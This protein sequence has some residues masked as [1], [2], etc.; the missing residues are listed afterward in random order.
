MVTLK[1]VMCKKVVTISKDDNILEASSRMAENGIS[2]LV[3]MENE[4]IVGIITR[5]DVLE[6]VVVKKLEPEKIKIK[7]IMSTPVKTLNEESHLI[8]AAGVMNAAQIKQLPVVNQENK[9]IG[10]VTQ[11]DVVRNINTLL[12]RDM[13][14]I[15]R[16]E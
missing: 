9:L 7:E 1:K 11:T 15:I 14:N 3:V 16:E 8:V 5:R 2:C 4:E 13:K 12:G 6:K 10:I